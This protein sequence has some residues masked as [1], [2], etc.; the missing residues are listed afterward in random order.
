M[1]L[2]SVVQHL[3]SAAG[4]VVS[5]QLLV[6]DPETHHLLGMPR[7][8]LI[9]VALS[10]LFSALLWAAE[11]QLRARDARQAGPAVAEGGAGPGS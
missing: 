3:S 7:L 2:T 11:T 6:D 8:G 10:A 4:A 9:A 1:S 5:S